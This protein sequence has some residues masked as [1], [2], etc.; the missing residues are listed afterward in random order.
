MREHIVLMEPKN[1]SAKLLNPV[2][3]SKLGFKERQHLEHWIERH[4]EILGSKL[5][6][7]TSEFD[8]FDKS[9]KR[10]DILALDEDGR[11]VIIELK[12][13][14][15][16]TAD[17]QAI[18]YAAFCANMTFD[19]IVRYRAAYAKIADDVARQQIRTFVDDAEFSALN[20]K[21]RI[22]LA[23]G[24]FE[25]QEL[26][27]CVLWLRSFGVDITCVE[28]ACYPNKSHLLIA[29]RVIIP[30]PEASE[31]IVR[32]EQ[33]QISES[34]LTRRQQQHL[35]RSRQIIAFFQKI[36]PDRA[37]TRP[38]PR[39]Y[40]Q[41]PSGY[42]GIHFEWWIRKESGQRYL[43]VCVHFETASAERNR[44][45]C[46][47]LR[48]YKGK[49]EAKT[50]K[51]LIFEPRWGRIWAAVYLRKARSTW[52]NDIAKWAAVKMAAL[53]KAVQPLLDAFMEERT[54]AKTASAT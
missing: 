15:A 44:Q 31:F 46:E 17:L 33:K 42:G 27:S 5:L 49:I 24:S 25:D 21:P 6:I 22:L 40:L 47:Y 45:L 11:L 18:R 29:P 23:A 26:T 14:A 30:L 3:L 34:G 39:N 9:K 38:V 10:L 13:D 4:P 54:E 2:D 52:D 51:G 12:R 48:K 16:G 1:G 28:L 50:G 8:R 36:M 35:E 41:V 53:V 20:S 32:T 43:D 7:I 37:P 19:E